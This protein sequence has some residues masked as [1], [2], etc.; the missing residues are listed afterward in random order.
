MDMQW[1]KQTWLLEKTYIFTVINL[2]RIAE[3]RALLPEQ[4]EEIRKLLKSNLKPAQI[5][6]KLRTSDNGTLATNQTISD[7]L[8]RIRRDDL[9]GRTPV[10]A[11][12]CILKE[13]NWVC[14]VKVNDQGS[15]LNLFFAHLGSIHLAQINHH[16]ALIDATYKTIQYQIPLLHII[17]QSAT[18]RLFSIGFCYMVNKDDRNY[19]WAMNTMKRHIWHPD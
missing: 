12:L 19:L 7:A 18:N 4:I 8:Q 13:T 14:N 16:V 1:L 17:S 11:L 6:L 3:P 2:E 15:I 9:D 10:K 5:L